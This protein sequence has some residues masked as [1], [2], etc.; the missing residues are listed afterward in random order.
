M[1]PKYSLVIRFVVDT[2]HSDGSPI[3][4]HDTPIVEL[5]APEQL[6]MPLLNKTTK[7][8]PPLSRLRSQTWHSD[9]LP[10][11]RALH[12]DCTA[13]TMSD[14]AARDPGMHTSKIKDASGYGNAVRLGQLLTALCL[15]PAGRADLVTHE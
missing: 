3:S 2:M 15:T 11:M 13:A 14:R 6:P 10:R 5:P 9:A 8:S 4:P 7:S 1:V 12:F